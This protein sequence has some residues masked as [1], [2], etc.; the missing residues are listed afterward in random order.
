MSDF[1]LNVQE[2]G[3][4]GDGVTDD[5]PALNTLFD[6]LVT[7]GATTVY[8]PKGTYL[9][10]SPVYLDG[11]NGVTPISGLHVFGDPATIIRAAT[12]PAG[13]TWTSTSSGMFM[14]RTS[15]STPPTNIVIENFIFDGQS[16]GGP[17]GVAMGI[18]TTAIT[19]LTVRNCTFKDI[20]DPGNGVASSPRNDGILLGDAP[21]VTATYRAKDVLIEK[22]RFVNIVRNGI[23]GLDVDGL[24]VRDCYFDNIDNSGIDC[25]PNNNL[26]YA[27][28]IKVTDCTFLNWEVAAVVVIPGASLRGFTYPAQMEGV[29]VSGCYMDGAA[30]GASGVLAYDWLDVTVSNNTIIRTND[31]AIFLQSCVLARVIGNHMRDIDELSGAILVNQ[32]DTVQPQDHVIHGNTVK[33]AAGYGIRVVDL[34]T[35][36]VMGNIVRVYDT[37]LA[38][39][40]GINVAVSSS[41]CKNVAV[42]GNTVVGGGGAG[43]VSGGGKPIV[44]A[45]ACTHMLCVG[46]VAQENGAG[47][48][49]DAIDND[50]ASTIHGF[51]ADDQRVGFGF[52]SASGTT[53]WSGHAVGLSS[54]ARKS[55]MEVTVTAGAAAGHVDVA[56]D[57]ITL[58]PVVNVVFSPINV[59]AAE[60]MQIA[61]GV[62]CARTSTGF[63]LVH[64]GNPA[65]TDAVF[66]VLGASS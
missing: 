49:T 21:L 66:Q 42:V 27:R 16:F 63:K 14:F 30:A 10:K 4:T 15:T 39:R 50:A 8:F 38:A 65:G 45:S 28:D 1:A 9:L 55:S 34:D 26:Q 51:N 6:A 17:L 13:G 41:T 36:S 56:S 32:A 62:Y 3:V 20:G 57:F 40:S 52:L 46:N 23:S 12:P 11:Q 25:E 64:Q 37:A 43:G 48:G 7:A 33:N 18:Y 5:A 29:K 22:C 58:T 53:P 47:L 31:P 19:G 54:A 60:M 61:G 44:I 59:A 2:H 24:V 35:G